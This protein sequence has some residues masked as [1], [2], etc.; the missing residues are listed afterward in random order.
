MLLSEVL[1]LNN[2]L[3]QLNESYNSVSLKNILNDV[4]I[5]TK[6]DIERKSSMN[7]FSNMVIGFDDLAFRY[8]KHIKGADDKWKLKAFN[9]PA[10]RAKIANT[11]LYKSDKPAFIQTVNKTLKQT[12]GKEFDIANIS[13]DSIQTVDISQAKKKPYKDGLQF[14]I[15]SD[16]NELKAIV[17]NNKIICM[18]HKYHESRIVSKPKFVGDYTI[19]QINQIFDDLANQD[20]KS[21]NE[22]AHKAFYEIHQYNIIDTQ[23]EIRKELECV[24]ISIAKL[25]EYY[26]NKRIFITVKTV[27]SDELENNDIT[28]KRLSREEYKAFVNREK[29]FLQ[30]QRLRYKNMLNDIK[31]QRI[32]NNTENTVIQILNEYIDILTDIHDNQMKILSGTVSNE[33]KRMNWATMIYPAKFVEYVY[34]IS[35]LKDRWVWNRKNSSNSIYIHNKLDIYMYICIYTEMVIDKIQYILYLYNEINSNKYDKEQVMDKTRLLV[36]HLKLIKIDSGMNMFQTYTFGSLRQ[37]DSNINAIYNK[38]LN[39]Y[40]NIQNIQA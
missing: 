3:K 39:A 34:K 11:V 2:K 23:S 31:N 27:M 13:E 6:Y 17:C 26:N 30:E 28:E 1:Q 10:Y 40:N 25:I 35:Y 37:E 4:N 14:W 21:F 8:F 36:Q 29:Y 20:N 32:K 12:I 24:G 7:E 33:L 38:L 18:V 22:F 19:E 15:D 16:N 9:D 5:T